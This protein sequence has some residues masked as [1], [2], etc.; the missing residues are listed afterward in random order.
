[1]IRFIYSLISVVPPGLLDP[2]NCKPRTHVR[3]YKYA[4]P[5]GTK[6]H[7]TLSVYSQVSSSSLVRNPILRFGGTGSGCSKGIIA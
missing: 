7:P 5:T 6:A 2:N 1:M 4:V 3:G